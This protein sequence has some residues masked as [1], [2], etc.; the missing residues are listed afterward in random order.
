[1]GTINYR[2]DD[3]ESTEILVIGGG[4]AAICAAISV[5]R[6]GCKVM[7]CEKDEVLGGNSGPKLGVH[8]SGAHSFHPYASETGII[9]EIEEDA[10]WAHAKI[11]T[12]SYH[13]NIAQQWDSLL[14][15]KL[16]ESGVIV[17]RRHYAKFPIMY[18]NRIESI[19]VEDLATYKTKRIDV[20]VAVIDGSGDGHIAKESVAD[21][22]MGRESSSEFGE[23]SAPENADKITLGTSVTALV[24]K[25]D[26]P[27]KFV[28]PPDTPP[29]EIG[30]GFGKKELKDCLYAHSAWNPNDDFCFLW[31]TET[32]G[33]L[34]TI[35]DE[36][37]IYEELI[38][39]LYSV[40][41]H[42]KNEAHIEEAIN[43]EL[44]WVSPKAGK[45]ESR[46]FM[47]DY[48]LSQ[49]DVENAT[50]F[51][52][53]VAYG[54]YAI[55]LH[56]P[57]GK[58][59]SQVEIIF[60]S[61]PPLW[62]MPYRCLYSRNVNNLFLA[63]RLC[64]ATHVAHGTMRLQKTLGAMGQAVGVAA[65]LCKKYDCAPREIYIHHI[66]ELQQTLL[67]EDATILNVPNKDKD[68]L[69]RHATITASSEERHG[70]AVLDDFVALDRVCGVQLWDWGDRLDS[71]Q[72]YLRNEK[73]GPSE[74][75]LSLSFYGSEKK[76]RENNTFRGFPHL[77]GKSSSN[78]MEWGDDQIISR[79]R[80][81]ADSKVII[82]PNHQGWVE[83][84][85][86]ESVKLITKDPTSDE[87]R[88]V[89]TL[90]KVDGISWARSRRW[91]DFAL[92]IWA[93]EGSDI[94]EAGGDC[95]L[96][97]IL[98]SPTYGEAHNIVNGWNRRFSTNPVNVWM[99]D[100]NKSFPQHLTLS[101]DKPVTFSKV[102]ITFDT[103]CRSY[104]DMPFNSE[105]EVSPMC[106]RDYQ[107][108][109]KMNGKW[110]IIAS[111][112]DNHHRWRVH[113]FDPVVT[114]QIR[115]VVKSAWN[116][117]YSARIYEIRVYR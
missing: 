86:P 45:R 99:S 83:F 98:P 28:P 74:L 114:K 30:Y 94:Y 8:P 110:Q 101:W 43:W 10:A 42:I 96:F 23:R 19:I 32:G 69:A 41:N 6:A 11:R 75:E 24:R 54:G 44:C 20:S 14:K 53:A 36:H 116:N 115:I 18:E 60:Y 102:Q 9:G 61:I 46:R 22:R 37:E 51:D 71:V 58:N 100:R 117:D 87:N 66:D 16:D 35:D 89:M 79:F 84:L 47:G 59:N 3:V 55:D 27:V 64:S 70:C 26:H 90:Q 13:Y 1:M 34:N 40:W 33:Q 95:H 106:V 73:D 38:R 72:L 7:L 103:L 39:Q 109:I 82:Q 25:A 92:R 63:G 77:R 68:D 93:N 48:I 78:R 21:Y 65:G 111:V 67:R 15:Y 76:W 97:R 91:Y 107:L 31:H 112:S 12:Y 88:Y 105:Q 104:R 57:T 29:Y 5:A 17:R 52:D 80:H 50:Q 49:Q 56:N 4:L 2:I 108:Q 85:F 62:N 113:K 81:V